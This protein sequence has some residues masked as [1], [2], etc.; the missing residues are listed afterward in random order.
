MSG[1]RRVIGIGATDALG[2]G[3]IASMPGTDTSTII[4]GMTAL[5][6][7]TTRNGTGTS[8]LALVPSAYG[9]HANRV[10]GCPLSGVK[11]TS[12]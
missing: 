6:R 7:I 3:T 1:S 12:R 10:C 4:L 9:G 5:T 8:F 2:P 11:Q